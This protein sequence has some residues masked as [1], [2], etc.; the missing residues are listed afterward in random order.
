MLALVDPPGSW[1]GTG[2]RHR[3]RALDRRYRKDAWHVVQQGAA[4][5]ETGVRRF[6]EDVERLST[7]RA[8]GIC[9]GRL[10]QQVV[11]N[12]TADFRRDATISVAAL[13]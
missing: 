10:A 1:G 12:I 3:D 4:F 8:T 6:P 11:G 7:A 13:A 2:E 5:L 9:A